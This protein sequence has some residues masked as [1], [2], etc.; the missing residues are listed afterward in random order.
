MSNGRAH[1]TGWT[2]AA[3]VSWFIVAFIALPVVVVS[4]FTIVGLEFAGQVA[5]LGLSIPFALGYGIVSWRSSTWAVLGA[6][7]AVLLGAWA[8]ASFGMSGGVL[9]LGWLAVTSSLAAMELR[10]P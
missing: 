3:S 1:H 4:A 7:Y 6:A 5:A 2:I 9:L 8:L 10:K